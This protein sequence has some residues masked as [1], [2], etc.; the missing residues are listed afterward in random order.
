[1]THRVGHTL[2]FALKYRPP[3]REHA[4]PV[5]LPPTLVPEAPPCRCSPGSVSTAT[6]DQL[7]A[8]IASVVRFTA[9]VPPDARSAQSLGVKREG[10]GVVI[11]DKGLVLTIGYLMLDAM[12]VMLYT[13]DGK[14]VP[15]QVVAYD[16]DTGFGMVRALTPLGV[17]PIALGQSAGLKARDPVLAVAHAGAGGPQPALVASRRPFAGA[18]EYMID[19]AIFTAPHHPGW[20]GA[21][22]IGPDAKLYGIG[23][24]QVG[25]AD[26]AVA[27]QNPGNMFVP[28]DLLRPIFADLLAEGRST[29]PERPWLG[30][31]TAE[32]DGRLVVTQVLPGGPAEQ[33]GLRRGD[34]ITS[35]GGTPVVNMIDFYHLLWSDRT[36]GAEVDLRLR[37]EGGRV[38][39]KVR[40]A[41][42][43]AYL[44][45]PKTY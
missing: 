40:S 3:L 19:Q 14:P 21:A 16:Y 6:P 45:P 20:S 41:S 5:T 32:L 31:Y 43:F 18:W 29:A 23:S 37:R 24:L 15:A 8:A 12:A 39:L 17:R 27:E 25:H 4:G 38:D 34:I 9:E 33:A 35:L 30:V 44:K 10:N 36:A 2:V 13:A 26:A 22:L 42:R 7:R 28:I 11:D 1:V